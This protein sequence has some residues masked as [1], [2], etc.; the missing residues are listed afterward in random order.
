MIREVP[1]LK[2]SDGVDMWMYSDGVNY[3]ATRRRYEG[4]SGSGSGSGSGGSATETAAE[5]PAPS[6]VAWKS[7][8]RMTWAMVGMVFF[9]GLVLT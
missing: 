6:N 1:E 8:P 2:S 4:D 9:T 7:W 5:A 3:E